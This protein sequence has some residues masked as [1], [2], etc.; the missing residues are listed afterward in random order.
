MT[1]PATVATDVPQLFVDDGIVAAKRGLVRTLHRG[2]RR[3]QP[4]L[5]PD[6]PWEGQRVYVYGSVH[7]DPDGGGFRMWYLSRIGR[8]NEHR[9]PEMR[10]R[11]GDLV[12]YATSA[13]G[14]QWDKPILGRHLFDGSTDN[15]IIMFDKHSPTVIVDPAAPA[16]ERHRMMAWEWRQARRGYWVAHSPDG[17][18][19][20]EYPV[21]PV[22]DSGDEILETV[23]VAQGPDGG[24]YFAFH[25]RWDRDRF[26]RRLIAVATSSDFQHWSVPKTILVPDERD[27]EWVQD[28]EQRSEFYGMAGF[29]Y[30]GQ[31]LGFLPVF[32]VMI[33][34]ALERDVDPELRTEQSPWEG[35]IAAQLVHSRDG[36]IWHRF[37]DRSPVIARGPRG[38]YDA[39]CI[40]CSADRP[41]VHGDEV[42]HYYT[43]IN[44]MHGGPLPPKQ[45]VIGRVSWRLD[46]FVSLDAGAFEGW[47]RTVPVAA[48]GRR[49]EVNADAGR[50]A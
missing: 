3:A 23:T 16:E 17:I 24:N 49:L 27:N 44:T 28:G 22:L 12:L 2:R 45:C 6:R 5:V 15:N 10:E 46:G 25:R 26:G 14:V 19:W 35:P 11:Q 9:S 50:A 36:L 37:A 7:H 13:D 33:H 38:S 42:W 8:G 1:R 4:V 41:V 34:S 20:T 39:G 32:D 18:D 29:S 48:G 47:V 30:G 43:G 21:N 31:F 40:L